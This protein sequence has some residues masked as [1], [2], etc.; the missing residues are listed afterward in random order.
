MTWIA[1]QAPIPRSRTEAMTAV[2]NQRIGVRATP[3]IRK[4]RAKFRVNPRVPRLVQS[5]EGDVMRTLK[6]F[7]AIGI[8]ALAGAALF[9]ASSASADEINQRKENQQDRIAQGVKSGELTA[10]E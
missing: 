6:G 8:A 5:G 2:A 4:S 7:Q 9:V 1:T 10:G 3:P